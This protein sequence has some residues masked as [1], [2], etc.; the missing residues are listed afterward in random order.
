MDNSKRRSA[1]NSKDSSNVKTL[2]KETKVSE[3]KKERVFQWLS[4]HR[5]E[6]KQGKLHHLCTDLGL[7]YEENKRYL[8]ILSSQFKTLVQFGRGSIRPNYHNWK[9]FVYAP[10]A[11]DRSAA[12]GKGKGWIQS[13][14]R[15][16]FF[17]FKNELGRL[18]WFETGRINICLRMPANPG[19][20]K[21]LLA[22]AFCWTG[23]ITDI[24][25]FDAFVDRVRFNGAH[26]V[27]ETEEKLPYLRID[28]LR[29]SNGITVKIGDLSHPRAV[30]IE[31]HRLK[32]AEELRETTEAFIDV[33][34]ELRGSGASKPEKNIGVV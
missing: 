31:F 27:Y 10:V 26:A 19:K 9:G 13:R 11:V 1:A 17:L 30:E 22:Q 8:W 18:E 12:P 15:N 7:Y 21:R 28:D 4:E 2:A 14:S 6:P 32:Q 34:K 16:R 25:L 20:L 5:D 24:N 29:E 3:S 23:L 33:V